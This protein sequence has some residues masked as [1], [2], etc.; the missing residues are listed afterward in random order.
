MSLLVSSKLLQQ[1]KKQREVH[2]GRRR[3]MGT[4]VVGVVGYTSA[5]KSTLVSAL[6]RTEL[7]TGER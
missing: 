7:Q 1:V 4:P 2:R 5:G 6:S 3:K